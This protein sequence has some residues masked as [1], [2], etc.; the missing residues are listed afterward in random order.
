VTPVAALLLLAFTL[1]LIRPVFVGARAATLPDVLPGSAYVPGRSLLRI[2]AQAAQVGGF[3]V[4]GILLLVLSPRVLL[5][6]NAICFALAAA[7]LRFGTQERDRPRRAG[8]ISRRSLVRDSIGGIREVISIPAVRRIVLFCWVVPMLAV[9]PEA[10]VVPYVAG[11]SGG[12]VS[13]GV[14]LTAVP[15]G[16]MA[17]EVL[18]NWLVSPSR[19]TQTVPVAAAVTFVPLL[20]FALHPAVALAI[21]ALFV[22]GLGAAIHLGLDR[23]LLQ[24]APEGLRAR[25]LSLQ[26]SGLMFWQ[27]IGYAGAGAAAEAVPAPAV[28]SIAGVT[29]LVAAAWYA[30]A[31]RLPSSHCHPVELRCGD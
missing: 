7:V 5:L 22:S 16:T 9:M 13:V 2:V 27:G 15:L 8:Q 6:V 25:T 12:T 4:S 14:L 24:V 26:A 20:L 3:A 18:A 29:G 19:Q 28:I 23:L 11:V 17:G 31:T 21:V 1:G 10:L 30:M